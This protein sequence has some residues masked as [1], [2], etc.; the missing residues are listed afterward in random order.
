MNAQGVFGFI[1]Q[2]RV[3]PVREFSLNL[4]NHFALLRF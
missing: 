4:L 3:Q 2:Y 1:N